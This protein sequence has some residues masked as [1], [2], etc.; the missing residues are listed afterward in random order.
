M[1][2]EEGGLGTKNRRQRIVGNT[3]RRGVGT[4]VDKAGRWGGR[5]GLLCSWAVDFCHIPCV[6]PAEISATKANAIV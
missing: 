4:D 5:V 2:E 6:L 3:Q 1:S